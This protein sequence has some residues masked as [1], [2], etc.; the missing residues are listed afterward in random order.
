MS[1]SPTPLNVCAAS[2]VSSTTYSSKITCHGTT[3][4]QWI[5]TGVD[6]CS[7]NTTGS[8]NYTS[9]DYDELDCTGKTGCGI[10]T[11]RMDYSCDEDE[12]YYTTEV[13]VTSICAEFTSS[14]SVKYACSGSDGVKGTLYTSASDCTGD[15]YS[16]SISSGCDSSGGANNSYN[17]DISCVGAAGNYQPVLAALVSLFFAVFFFS[18]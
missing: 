4:T 14:T 17:Y 1:G 12:I 18:Q 15:S 13:Y 16:S 3:A 10:A 7:G 8:F 6:D 9:D 2:K 11:V 5:W